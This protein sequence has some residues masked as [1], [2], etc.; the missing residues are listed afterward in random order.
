MEHR[1]DLAPQ[2]HRRH[3]LP[4]AVQRGA[5]LLADPVDRQLD[6]EACVDDQ[7]AAPCARASAARPPRRRASARRSASL[8]SPRAVAPPGAPP[9]ARRRPRSAPARPWPRRGPDVAQQ[10]FLCGHEPDST[11]ARRRRLVSAASI[12]PKTQQAPVSS[13]PAS[14]VGPA[15]APGRSPMPSRLLPA[16]IAAPLTGL[17]LGE[18]PAAPPRRNRSSCRRS[19]R[20]AL[21]GPR[22][23]RSRRSGPDSTAL[24]TLC[25]GAVT[26]VTGSHRLDP[27]WVDGDR[28]AQSSTSAESGG[29]L[30]ADIQA[31][32]AVLF[33]SN[34]AV[35]VS[36]PSPRPSATSGRP[37]QA[38]QGRSRRRVAAPRE[39][40]RTP[41]RA[42]CAVVPRACLDARGVGAH[43]STKG[44]RA[45][46]PQG[47]SGRG[48]RD[49]GE[50]L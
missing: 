40:A 13:H 32:S 30:P 2:Q 43:N 34:S 29:A 50:S 19:D 5:C 42:V 25:R 26:G 14:A 4:F 24:T 41:Q 36:A 6:D 47:T 21:L 45:N 18:R 16:A 9:P 37:R 49:Q 46:A 10:S 23:A 20:R 3:Q 33:S 27:L 22:H 28:G 8:P 31:P 1:G 44:A 48:S 17:P 38:M 39:S 35:A 7:H 11:A 12:T 15:L